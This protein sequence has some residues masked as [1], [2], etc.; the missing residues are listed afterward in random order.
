MSHLVLRLLVSPDVI[1]E[2]QHSADTEAANAQSDAAIVYDA[3]AAQSTDF[4]PSAQP[5]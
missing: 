3:L 1:V 4:G 2:T 5:I